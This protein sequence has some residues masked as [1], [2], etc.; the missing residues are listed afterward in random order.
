[1]DNGSGASAGPHQTKLVP[2]RKK[3]KPRPAPTAVHAAPAANLPSASRE[4]CYNAGG[5][6]FGGDRHYLFYAL[7]MQAR[8]RDMAKK[9][10]GSKTGKQTAT[11]QEQDVLLKSLRAHKQVAESCN[12]NVELKPGETHVY[13]KRSDDEP[14]LLIEK[15]KSFFKR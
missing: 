1:V 7:P 11:E 2:W 4:I 9:S 6:V 14:G 13:V 10:S 3:D 12:E 5:L 15:R 8:S